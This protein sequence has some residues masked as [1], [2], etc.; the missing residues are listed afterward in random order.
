[1]DEPLKNYSGFIMDGKNME[2][3][4]KQGD[5]VVVDLDFKAIISGEI[6]AIS[7]K[8]NTVICRL[9]LDRDV[10][11]LVFDGT[12][13]YFEESLHNITVIGKVVEIKTLNDLLE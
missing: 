7:Y 9:L 12:K 1:M 10:V 4:I 8:Q 5:H 13:H 6:Y 11:T 3:I 2:P